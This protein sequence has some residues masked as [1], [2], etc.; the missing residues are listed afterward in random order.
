[1]DI[2]VKTVSSLEKIFYNQDSIVDEFSEF[3]CLKGEIFSFQISF[4][5]MDIDKVMC[6]IKINS[7]LKDYI[8]IYNVK[9]VPVGMASYMDSDDYFITKKSA[10]IPDLLEDN[11][12]CFSLCYGQWRTIWIETV[13]P[14]KIDAGNYKIDIELCNKD[15]EVVAKSNFN[16]E[17]IDK[18]L[19]KQKIICTHWFHNDCLCTYYQVEP[20][21]KEHWLIIE[22]YIENYVKYGNNMLLTP[23]FTPPLDTEIGS[24]RMTMQLVD[25]YETNDGYKFGF[26]KL[27]KYLNLAI[28]K[29]ISY[30]EFSHFFTQWGAEFTPK[31]VTT[32]GKRI[33]GWDISAVSD[34]YKKFVNQ[35]ITELKVFL[36]NKN[37]LEKCYFH[38]SDEPT[39]ETLETYTKA[40][41]VVKDSLY[42][43]NVMDALSA[44]KFYENGLVKTP[45]VAN[46]HIQTFLDNKVKPL[47]TYYCGAQQNN[48]VSNSFISMPSARN[49]IIGIQLF[50][51]NIEGFLQWGFNFWY[52]QLSKFPINPYV[53]TDGDNAFPSGGPFLVYPNKNGNLYPSIREIVFNEAIQD[54]RALSIIAE[55]IGH[56]ETIKWL[57]NISNQEITFTNY[58]HGS[59]YI[60]NTRKLINNKIKSLL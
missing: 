52:S 39:E 20:F 58:P 34:E 44:Y 42:D 26:D 24:E 30:F 41:N 1:M 12:G 54:A 38:I 10:L 59:E 49:R 25:V 8:K 4:R 28:S 56:T 48:Y 19:P 33:F 3:S 32:D 17:I 22:K 14:E 21:S 18:I 50:K 51:Y 57:E 46:N 31:I 36:K 53:T 5:L 2:Q 55:Q 7:P 37:L 29:G 60:L 11:N 6:Y 13:I 40:V 27:D 15:N 45:V 16:I 9:S 43:C 23:I 35:L 47:W